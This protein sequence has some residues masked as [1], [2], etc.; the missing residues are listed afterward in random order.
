MEK[1]YKHQII[2][3]TPQEEPEVLVSYN[4]YDTV[5]GNCIIATT[6]K[7]VCYIGFGSEDD[8]VNEL[9]DSYPNSAI[10]KQ[11]T[12]LQKKVVSYFNDFNNK[13]EIPF[14]VRG[15]HFQVDVWKE[16]LK[17]PAGKTCSYK[18]IAEKLNKPN[19]TRAVGSA[20][21]RNPISVL[22]PCH[23]VIRSDGKL[24]G[25]HWG[26]ELKKLMLSRESDLSV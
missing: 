13:M 2:E 11:S 21:G 24:G 12:E 17:I 10:F 9:M 16:L 23:R 7:G 18:F 3:M 14:H 15:T 25:Y 19:A 1:N 20:V 22:I 6:D 4:C 8:L 26:L 5:Y